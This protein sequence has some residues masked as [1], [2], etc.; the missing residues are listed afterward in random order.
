MTEPSHVVGEPRGGR[1]GRAL[2]ENNN[3]PPFTPHPPPV[4]PLEGR[5]TCDGGRRQSLNLTEVGQGGLR[6]DSFPR[7]GRSGKGEDAFRYFTVISNSTRM[8][9]FAA[10]ELWSP[11]VAS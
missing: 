1:G 6:A 4:L 11:G 8:F 5:E 7:T 10:A 2:P 3:S 9:A